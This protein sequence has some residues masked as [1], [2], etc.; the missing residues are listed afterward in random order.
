V[1]MTFFVDFCVIAELTVLKK[2]STQIQLISWDFKQIN[3]I[4]ITQEKN[5]PDLSEYKLCK[6]DL[7]DAVGVRE[8]LDILDS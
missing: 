4:F 7:I 2:V 3:Q 6:G 8:R 1:E 5:L